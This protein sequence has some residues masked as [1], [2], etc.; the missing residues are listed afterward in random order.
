[1]EGRREER[2]ATRDDGAADD[3]DDEDEDDD[4]DDD[5]GGA[6]RPE[7]TAILPEVNKRS[8]QCFWLVPTRGSKGTGTEK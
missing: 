5:E 6:P 8:L 7:R 2:A 1:M 3:D 4:D